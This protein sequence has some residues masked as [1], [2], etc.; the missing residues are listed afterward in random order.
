MDRRGK[1]KDS[2]GKGK[3]SIATVFEEE[4]ANIQSKRLMKIF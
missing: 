1:I 4:V 3:R 2:N